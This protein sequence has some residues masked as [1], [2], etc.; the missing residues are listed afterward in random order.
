MNYDKAKKLL[1]NSTDFNKKN[2][3][4][5]DIMV[6]FVLSDI[7]DNNKDGGIKKIKIITKC[8]DETAALLWT[9]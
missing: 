9:T 7:A 2:R 4:E 5:T 1:Y 6:D 8:D 3:N